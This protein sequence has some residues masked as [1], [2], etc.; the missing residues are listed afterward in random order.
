[1]ELQYKEFDSRLREFLPEKP[2]AQQVA[3]GFS[4]TEGPVWCGDYLI[5][6]DIPMNRIVR[7]DIRHNG[8]EVTTFKS[9]SG[10]SNGLTLDKDGRLVICESSTR[11]IT[12]FEYDGSLTVLAERYKGK[13]LN[14]PN[15]IVV[16]S[17]GSI[18][19][20]DPL[21]G[22]PTSPKELDFNGVYRISPEGELLLLADDFD[23][24][25]GLAFSPD[26]SILYVNDTGKNTIRAYDVEKDGSL[27]HE[28]L[29][30]Q[31]E[32]DDFGGPD[33]M[34]LDTEGTIYCTGVGGFWIISPEGKHLG[35]I[36]L[37]ELPA[38]MAW[39]D[40]D[41]KTMYFT[42]RSSIYRI[43]FNKTGIA[44][45]RVDPESF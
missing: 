17:D 19:F 43:R 21:F 20:T 31:M 28:R 44:P 35:T 10:Q 16:R 4:F 22:E 3:A 8:P 7:L 5:F 37:P 32:S 9:P 45:Y 6:S 39:G 13:R 24:P 18:Y 25:N 15:D 14:A 2:S 26:E 29:F 41:W 12:R 34:K 1:M 33:G 38:N 27:T 42:C 23:L 40:A 11:R 30:F 36:A